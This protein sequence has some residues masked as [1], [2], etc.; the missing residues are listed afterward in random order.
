[1]EQPT[2]VKWDEESILARL[3]EVAQ[4]ELNM[5]TEQ[6]AAL[7][8]DAQLLDSMQLDSLAQV[9]LMSAVERDF[10]CVFELEE[11]QEIETLRDLVRMIA[12]RATRNGR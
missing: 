9:V 12:Q 4:G 5:T 8:P 7:D 1:M 6:I 2:A 10:G 11:L 3:K